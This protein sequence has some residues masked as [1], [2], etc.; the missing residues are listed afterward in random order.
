MT[1]TV[2]PVLP[3][4]DIVVFPPPIPTSDDFIKRVIG[5]PGDRLA[6]KNGVV[7]LNGKALSEPYVPHRVLGHR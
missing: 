3:L 4:R 2:L 1:T 7:Y 6:I 5:R